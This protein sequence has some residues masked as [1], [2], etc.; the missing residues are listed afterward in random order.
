MCAW[1]ALGISKMLKQSL[2]IESITPLDRKIIRAI[3]KED[4]LESISP[5]N[6]IVWWSESEGSFAKVRCG[7]INFFSDENELQ[8]WQKLNPDKKGTPLSV[9][10]AIAQSQTWFGN[11]Y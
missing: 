5:E 1:D 8:R 10:L 3:F 2:I 9:N 4:K 11:R 7:E 6:A